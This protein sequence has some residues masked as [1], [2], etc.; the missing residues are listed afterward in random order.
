MR[1]T[2]C[3]FAEYVCESGSAL[4]HLIC[5]CSWPKEWIACLFV[6]GRYS[7][8]H[9][10]SLRTEEVTIYVI[11]GSSLILFNVSQQPGIVSTDADPREGRCWWDFK[12]FDRFMTFHSFRV[13]LGFPLSSAGCFKTCQRWFRQTFPVS[14]QWPPQAALGAVGQDQRED[15]KEPRE[16]AKRRGGKTD[17]LVSSLRWHGDERE[18]ILKIK[19]EAW[20]SCQQAGNHAFISWNIES[21]SEWKNRL[22]GGLFILSTNRLFHS[23]SSSLCSVAFLPRCRSCLFCLS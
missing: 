5:Q 23:I 2:V 11:S 10:A 15:K 14:Y 12:I 17:W 7:S 16:G 3:M 9:I 6:W 20:A 18:K 8:K 19:R 4:Q 13:G 21:M 1:V 22:D